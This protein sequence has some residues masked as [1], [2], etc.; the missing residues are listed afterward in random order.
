VFLENI[1]F[2]S[3]N[4]LQF[5]F[6]YLILTIIISAIIFYLSKYNNMQNFFRMQSTILFLRYSLILSLVV[7]LVIFLFTFFT[8]IYTIYFFSSLN[9]SNTYY[10][11]PNLSMFYSLTFGIFS[12]NTIFN[13]YF[14]MD[15]FGFILLFLAYIVG[16][17]SIFALDTRL[18]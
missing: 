6:L 17:I 8:Y 16:I 9:I 18:Y 7:S 15:F 10:I 2:L 3:K 12:S 5:N 13:I 1:F 4:L 11:L 14:S